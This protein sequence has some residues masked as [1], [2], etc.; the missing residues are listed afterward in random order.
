MRINEYQSLEEFT[1]QYTGE[2]S[3]SDGHWFGLEFRYE[4]H[5]YRLHTG[6]MHEN[7][8]ER[9]SEG[10]E[11]LF[12][13]YAMNLHASEGEQFVR[14]ASFASMDELLCFTGIGSRPFR[15]VIMDDSTQILGQ[16]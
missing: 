12:G 7:D 6:I 16:D 8:P 10:R 9:D 14:L 3:P 1:S 13:L 11:I 5:D 4:A 15:E 2:W